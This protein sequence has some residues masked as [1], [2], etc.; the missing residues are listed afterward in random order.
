MNLLHLALAQSRANPSVARAQ[1]ERDS[2]TKRFDELADRY[3]KLVKDYNRLVDD[4]ERFIEALKLC[5]EINPF[6]SI[7]NTEARDAAFV[8]IKDLN[9]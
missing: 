1:D 7:K 4:R 5:S 9:K 6:G 8:I 2:A 3:N